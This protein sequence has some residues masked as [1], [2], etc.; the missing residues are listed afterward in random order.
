[1]RS[2]ILSSFVATAIIA[3]TFI[4]APTASAGSGGGCNGAAIQACISLSGG[5]T[6][7][8]DL[9]QNGAPDSSRCTAYIEIRKSNG[10][11]VWGGPY[12]IK[13]NGRRGPVTNNIV[14]APPTSGSAINRIHVYTC[15]GNFHHTL[16]SK[17][18][19]YP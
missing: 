16:D 10:N 3:G 13:S 1:M 18:Q 8:A 5:T 19:Y 7:V 17:R 2:R 15:A 9:Y 11:S 14:T 4:V 6:L 12:D